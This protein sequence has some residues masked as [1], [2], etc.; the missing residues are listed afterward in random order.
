[1]ACRDVTADCH[2]GVLFEYPTLNGGERSW[3]A[4]LRYLREQPIRFTALAPP[5]GPLSEALSRSGVRVESFSCR[6]E[7]G[8]KRELTE[9]RGELRAAVDRL[10]VD[11]LH[12]N[13]LSMSRLAGPVAAAASL[14][15]LGHIRDIVRISRQAMRDVNCHRRV[16]TVS[17]A[18][19]RFHVDAGLEPTRSHVIHNGV[20]L[21]EFSPGPRNTR[22]LDELGL[23]H[24]CRLV[25]NIGQLGLRKGQDVLLSAAEFV[26][27]KLPN[28]HF[29]LVGQRDSEKA[30]SREFET[31]LHERT[32][33]SGLGGHVHFLGR[34]TDV[35]D[36]LR[37]FDL[38][39]HV[40]HQEPLGRV[41]LESAAIGCAVVATD[42]GGTSEIFPDESGSAVLVPD[43]DVA[44]LAR[45]I[46]EL[47]ALPDR[48][49]ELGQA[50]RRRCE[51]QFSAELA[52]GRLLEH[53]RALAGGCLG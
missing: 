35:V 1:M 39:A 17:A 52:A 53:Y 46:T 49:W 33:R 32:A 47:L 5:D 6:S 25:G 2:V 43:N 28:T 36:L 34:R 24:D 19:L 14:P 26:V 38:I 22:L 21:D 8:N 3:L 7:F 37:G 10:N 20:D 9:L 27:R 44:A 15:S 11:L 23:E 45:A 51:R 18:T 4:N 16:V 31:A 30:E 41:L 40:A 50:A 12:A 48:R 29:V 42:V 13:S